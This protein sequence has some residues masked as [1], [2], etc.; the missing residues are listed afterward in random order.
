MSIVKSP[1]FT[2]VTAQNKIDAIAANEALKT[3]AYLAIPAVE[4]EADSE[5]NIVDVTRGISIAGV[6]P[7]G[8]YDFTYGSSTY[9]AVRT[10]ER[11]KDAKMVKEYV[12]YLIDK[13]FRETNVYPGGKRRKE[14]KAIANDVI[15]C[16]VTKTSGVRMVIPPDSKM[17]IV[18]A[19]SVKKVDET[20]GFLMT[21]DIFKD[22]APSA[23]TPEFL[24][25]VLS[26][27]KTSSYENICLA[28]EVRCEGIGVDFLTWLWMASETSGVLPEGITVT[29]FGDI[30]FRNDEQ[31]AQGAI[32][33]KMTKGTPWEGNG[34]LAALNDGKKVCSIALRFM[35]GDAVA[36]EVV[37]DENFVFKKFKIQEVDKELSDPQAVFADSIIAIQNFVELFVTVFKRFLNKAEENQTLMKSWCQFL[38]R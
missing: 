15:K 18:E 19:S 21:T 13:E 12:A 7:T 35:K 28:D 11:V 26:G 29:P 3:K 33:T 1:T 17:V 6:A 34:P 37:V 38:Q 31:S 27:D 22:N 8:E 5:Q 10:R 16:N 23:M 14:I 24:F 4:G 9:F 32:M 30:C 20:L 2:I 25:N 36:Y